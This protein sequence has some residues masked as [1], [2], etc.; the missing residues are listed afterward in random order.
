MCIGSR[1]SALDLAAVTLNNPT[2][3]SQ[4]GPPPPTRVERYDGKDQDDTFRL[5]ADD[6]RRAARAGYEAVSHTWEGEVLLVTYKFVGLPRKA[7]SRWAALSLPGLGVLVGGAFVALGPLLPWATLVDEFNVP[8]TRSGVEGID[9]LVTIIVGIG[10]ALVGRTMARGDNTR[11]ATMTLVFSVLTFVF[12]VI[13]TFDITQAAGGMAGLGTL[14]AGIGAVLASVSS[15]RIR[16][17][18]KRS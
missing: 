15:L 9:G 13:D 3:W 6:A 18:P 14:V 16:T 1:V 7:G 11:R 5:F 4:A 10:I 2:S 17:A 8:T 12:V